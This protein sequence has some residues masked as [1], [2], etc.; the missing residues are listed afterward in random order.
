VAGPEATEAT[1]RSAIAFTLLRE[2][3]VEEAISELESVLEVVRR[4]GD[5]AAEGA[6]EILLNA[7]YRADGAG[8]DEHARLARL[9]AERAEV[10]FR[11]AGDRDGRLDALSRLVA[12]FIEA[13]DPANVSFT[14]TTMEEI[15]PTVGGWWRTYADAVAAMPS[16]PA[17]SARLFHR[18]I[19]TVD[20]LSDPDH[21]R[22]ECRRKLAFVERG[23]DM[24]R[25]A[26]GATGQSWW[27]LFTEA[28][29][30]AMSSA[31]GA[32]VEARLDDAIRALEAQRTPIRS[33]VKQR[34]I[35]GSAFPLY[36]AKAAEADR[37]GRHEEALD[38]LELNTSR[39]L[40][41]RAAMRSLWSRS[42]TQSFDRLRDANRLV[43]DCL[44][45]S[46][47]SRR[48]GEQEQLRLAL[49][50][51]R[52][53]SH[54]VQEE[55]V[56]L[57]PQPHHVFTPS[58]SAQ[59]REALDDATALVVFSPNGW[60]SVI[61]ASGVS[62]VATIDPQR[63]D[64]ACSRFHALAALPHRRD[65]DPDAE[66]DE[67]GAEIAEA[68]LGPLAHVLG[69]TTR[70][71]VVPHGR[72]WAV[73]LARLGP[74][75]LA[76]THDVGIVPSLSVARSLLLRRRP[77]RRVPRFVGLGNPD[78]TL[79][80]AAEEVERVAR[81]FDDR[82]VTTGAGQ[83]VTGALLLMGDADVVHLACHGGT[84][85]DYPELSY[86]L[87][88][89]TAGEPSPWW[90]ED[91]LRV[92]M[93]PRLVVLSAC[94]AGTSTDLEGNEYIGFPGVFMVAGADAVVAPLWA[95]PDA[96]T[97]ALMD[98]F[99]DRAAVAGPARALAEAQ[100]I[101]R[102]NPATAGAF[103]WAGFQVFGLP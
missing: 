30:L 8:G 78:E 86:L 1:E 63:V 15:D 91:V 79:P 93:Q 4:A 64:A 85:P 13:H 33:E 20:V 90:A 21:W 69:E 32:A 99:Y 34:E 82:S 50:R 14:L 61:R 57:V 58:A 24:D 56:S 26:A 94:H 43:V 103:H 53:A 38:T 96:S 47:G 80:G 97:V 100:D 102:S 40:L 71:L 35:S 18:A 2:G 74:R 37:G 31:D 83:D 17:E 12:G 98:A 48:G 23:S 77:V 45:R 3:R 9:H 65:P 39:S 89:G 72:M 22:G 52:E 11:R 84:F 7:A 76:S 44:V 28:M 70:L 59:L 67:L 19:E 5:P 36:L 75:P 51:R 81:H 29:R 101:V 55:L 46:R 62:K 41:S 92:A 88:G 54:A 60:V 49:K 25:G 6:T 73:P 27:R 16:D 66:L 95:I 10:A 68:C 42:P 87:I